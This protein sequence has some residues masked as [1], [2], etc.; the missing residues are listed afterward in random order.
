MPTDYASD[1]EQEVRVE[2]D[3]RALDELDDDEDENEDGN[4]DIASL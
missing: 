1:D 2:M 4:N 3:Q